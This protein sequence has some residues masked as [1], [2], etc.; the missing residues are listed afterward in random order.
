VS[1]W[2]SLKVELSSRAR[3]DLRALDH[4]PRAR[5]MEAIARY[6]DTGHGDVVHLKGTNRPGFRLRVGVW[7]VLFELDELTGELH[8][9]LV[10]RV[11]HRREAYRK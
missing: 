9:M 6:A 4:A 10:Q 2:S 3:R 7:R 5:V 1:A 11:L 8:V